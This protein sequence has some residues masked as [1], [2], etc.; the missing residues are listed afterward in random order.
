MRYRIAILAIV[1]MISLLQAQDN[2]VIFSQPDAVF[3][4]FMPQRET[5]DESFDVWRRKQGGEWQKLNN[6]PLIRISSMDEI[7]SRLGLRTELYTEFFDIEGGSI[8]D[9]S[10]MQAWNEGGFFMILSYV[11]P[12]VGK[13]HGELFTDRDIDIGGVYEYQVRYTDGGVIG[14]TVSVT[15]GTEDDIPPPENLELRGGDDLVEIVWD[16]E[17]ELMRKGEV[18][19]WNIYRAE[20]EGGLFERVNWDPYI[21]LEIA[22]PGKQPSEKNSYIDEFVTNGREYLYMVKAANM[23]GIESLPSDILRVTPE[24]KTPPQSPEGLKVELFGL[25]AKISWQPVPDSDL[26]GYEINRTENPVGQWTRIYPPT[27]G[28]LSTD[29]GYLDT[30]IE[31]GQT[32]YYSVTAVDSAGNRSTASDYVELY[33]EDNL[34][35]EPPVLISVETDSTGAHLL[36]EESRDSDV[37]GY[38]VLRSTEG[39]TEDL[40]LL[41][42][43]PL[44]GTTFTDSLPQRSQTRYSYV[45]KAMD[46]AF[47][48]SAPSNMLSARMPDI[49]P[50]QRPFIEE[51]HTE[52]DSIYIRWTRNIEPDL[53]AYRLYVR[54]EE[55]GDF[56]LYRETIANSAYYI[57]Q[58]EQRYAF[59]VTAID[60]TGNESERSDIKTVKHIDREPPPS[61]TD[62]RA[63]L[64]DGDIVLSW[65]AEG[66][67]AGFVIYKRQDG[68]FY[69]FAE[70][71]SSPYIDK[72]GMQAETYQY[73]LQ[74]R[75]EG[76]NLSDPVE[77]T[78]EGGE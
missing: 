19:T 75:D 23:F 41:N 4:R 61:P 73:R 22:P 49:V 9:Q 45:V 63:E 26:L 5:G 24:D 11:L 68:D 56:T 67:V 34:P 44:I 7:D 72:Y 12:E 78:Y 10:F 51:A 39:S 25:S 64:I 16:R 43:R 29:T 6:T 31:M 37:M 76:W 54:A 36:W 74:A 42:E 50:P 53:M 33:F 66:D 17:R 55:D 77:T 58:K 21:A 18:I 46:R 52:G 32:R 57:P 38:N 65:Q 59:T 2:P 8:T 27:E 15:H 28:L 3:I 71:V 48:M 1:M 13:L 47:N 35:P 70:P 62:F 20:A 30:D 69:L 14:E 40:F 60:S